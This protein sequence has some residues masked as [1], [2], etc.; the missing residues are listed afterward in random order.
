M[1]IPIGDDNPSRAR[2]LVTYVLIA[3]NVAVFLLVNVPAI[4]AGPE[5]LGAVF[6][7][8]GF[9]VREP[10]SSNL[11]T[12]M[13]LHG[14]IWHLLGNMWV[15]WIVGDNVEDKI[16]R[17]RYAILYVSGG[18]I[19]SW[20]FVATSGL[21]P[22]AAQALGD[23]T[24]TAAVPPLVGASGSIFA[25]MGTYMV[26]FPEARIRMLLF[27]LFFVHVIP[28]RAKWIIGAWVVQDLALTILA[29]GPAAGSVATAAHVGGALFGI[30]AGLW[31]KPRVGGGGLGDAWDVHTGFASSS[32][33]R[34]RVTWIENSMPR[35][36]PPDPSESH[37]VALEVQIVRD[38]RAGRLDAALDLYP[39]YEAM[40][41]EQPLPGPVQIEIAHE[42]FR[43]RLAREAYEAYQRYLETD[44]NGPD[45]AEACFRLGVLLG[46]SLDKRAEAVAYL[47]RALMDHPDQMA[48]AFAKDE[49]DRLGG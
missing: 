32:A 6:A 10:F 24:L 28:V 21:A 3:I 4:A 17:A 8:W 33:D 16:G 5:Q 42:L 31:Q 22:A 44:P 37:L 20:A 12:A 47:Q 27:V 11:L 36:A 19:A 39:R 30:L 26:F 48:R 2:P 46:R 29:R 41:R 40:A 9:D 23:A 15:L 1:F 45:A 34:H 18:L 43:R 38:V 14:S 49:I 13:F 25:V 35:V 7:A